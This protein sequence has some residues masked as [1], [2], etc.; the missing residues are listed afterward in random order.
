MPLSHLIVVPTIWAL[1][2][3]CQTKI[4]IVA[5]KVDLVATEC[6]IDGLSPDFL[7]SL[8]YIFA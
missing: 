2:A 6:V 8:D 5:R 4:S 3:W 1:A 7:V